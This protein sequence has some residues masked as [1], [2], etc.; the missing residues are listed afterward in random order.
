MIVAELF[1]QGPRALA[2]SLSGIVNWLLNGLIGYTFPFI[3]VSY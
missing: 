1:T 3:L 2:V